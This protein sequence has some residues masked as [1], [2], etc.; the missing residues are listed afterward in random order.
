MAINMNEIDVKHLN[1]NKYIVNLIAAAKAYKQRKKGKAAQFGCLVKRVGRGYD[2]IPFANEECNCCLKS[3]G[4][5]RPDKNLLRH[6]HTVKHIAALFHVSRS[7]LLN[8]IKFTEGIQN[9]EHKQ[10]LL[11]NIATIFNNLKSIME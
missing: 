4:K 9:S 10:L 8:L 5:A 6:C 7:D 11:M 2:W 3:N 1:A